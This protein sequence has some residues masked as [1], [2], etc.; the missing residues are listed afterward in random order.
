MKLINFT[1][2]VRPE[3]IRQEHRQK[4]TTIA[5]SNENYESLKNRGKTGESFNDVITKLLEASI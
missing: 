2:C 3:R 5:V 4:M 1:W